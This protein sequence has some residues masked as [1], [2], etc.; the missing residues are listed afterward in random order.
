ML[1]PP[2]TVLDD[3][4]HVEHPERLCDGNEEIARQYR[5]GVILQEGRPALIAT[6]LPGRPLRHVLSD[7]PRRYAD[8]E[9]EP[10]LVCNALFTPRYV[11]NSHTPDQSPKF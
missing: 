10:Q 9:L 8:P 3:D 5:L 6:K 1:E 11:L 7:R 2:C 4:E